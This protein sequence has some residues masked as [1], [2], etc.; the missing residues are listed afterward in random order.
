MQEVAGDVTAIAKHNKGC[1]CKKSGCLKKYCECFQANI[2]C[3]ENCKCMDCKNFEGREERRDLFHGEDGT[4]V[5]YIQRAT[6]AAINRAIGTS[7][8]CTL[9]ASKRRKT[10]QLVFGATASDQCI[11]GI[12]QFQQTL[13]KFSEP[14]NFKGDFKYAIPLLF[15]IG[16]ETISIDSSYF[17]Q[18]DHFRAPAASS[19]MLPSPVSHTAPAAF[20]RSSRLSYKSPLADILRPQDV[21]ELCSLLVIVSAEATKALAG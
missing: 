15:L 10:Q 7:R 17:T 13:R 20:L 4:H 14:Y 5:S 12:A 3:S 21:K 1:N 9:P 6:N 8:L 11:H 16:K 2:V 18:E 19:S